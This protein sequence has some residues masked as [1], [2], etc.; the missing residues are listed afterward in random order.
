VPTLSAPAGGFCAKVERA[1]RVPTGS[2]IMRNRRP[3]ARFRKCRKRLKEQAEEIDPRKQHGR[4]PLTRREA[5]IQL[6]E[7]PMN[8]SSTLWDGATLFAASLTTGYLQ[9]RSTSVQIAPNLCLMTIQFDGRHYQVPFKNMRAESA[10]KIDQLTFSQSARF[11]TRQNTSYVCL[12]RGNKFLV[13]S[14]FPGR[15]LKIV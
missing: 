8:R 13:F 11:P 3:K 7:C 5:T 2:F 12:L 6:R 14:D 10:I 1:E 4:R 9:A 15:K